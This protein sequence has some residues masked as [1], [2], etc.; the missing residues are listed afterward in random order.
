MRQHN[1]LLVYD[2]QCSV[3]DAYCRRV[4]I[5]DSEGDLELVNARLA[6]PLME[7]VTAHGLDI[8][9]GLVLKVDTALYYG[10][11][12][13][14][15]LALLSDA[16]DPFNWLTYWT[17]HSRRLANI[18]YPIL[19]AAHNLLLKLQ[20]KSKVNNLAKPGNDRY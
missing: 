5:R 14:H 20:G 19:R 2:H 3:C 10:S 7:E 17:F 9:Q 12:A 6:G 18:I 13:I 1:I 4:H 16:A 11:E 15:E 8:D